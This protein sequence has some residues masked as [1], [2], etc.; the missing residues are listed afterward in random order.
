MLSLKKKRLVYF[1]G[2][3]KTE[4]NARMSGILGGKG[5]GLAEMSRMGI[6][7][8]AGFT[9]ST[10][11][12][13]FFY[14]NGK[15]YPNSLK[16]EVENNLKKLEI[17]TGKSFGRGENPLLVSVRSGAAVSMPGMM[18]TILNLGI[19]NEVVESLAK[20]TNDERFAYD[21]YRRFIQMFGN[22]VKK[23]QIEEFEDAILKVK[24]KYN[25]ED[26]KKLQKM[27]LKEIIDLYFQIY[28]K[29]V[30][31]AFPQDPLKQ[32][33]MAIDAV[34][35]SW[36]NERAIKFREFNKIKNISGTAV[37]IQSMVFG[38]YGENSGTGVCFSRNPSTG[39]KEIY[40]EYLQNAQG[41]DVVAGIR[42]PK[43]IDELKK[44]F[45]EIYIQLF[46]AIQKLENHYRD[47]Q[48]IEFTVSDGKLYLLQ[49]RSGKRT[50]VASVKCAV[51]MVREGL[52]SKEEAIKRVK[53]EDIQQTLFPRIL[54][55]E[56]KR[57]INEKLLIASGLNASIGA[58][59]GEIVFNSND[60][61]KA[62][63][64]GKKVVL[65]RQNTSPEDIAGMIVAEAV[66]TATG[67]MTSHAAIVSRSIG[68]PCV[69]CP[70]AIIFN[71]S[72]NSVAINGKI[73]HKGDFITID[74]TNGRVFSGKLELSKNDIGSDVKE[75]LSWCDDICSAS[76]RK[77][78]FGKN[79]VLLKGFY[80]MANADL[81]NDAMTALNFGA[82]GIG[83]CR[84]EHMF[85][86][87]EKLMP[88]RAMICSDTK[89]DRIAYLR[90]I[91][92]LQ[93]V[94]F[95]G[96]FFQMN[97]KEVIVRLLDPPLHEFLPKNEEELQKLS[98]YMNKDVDALRER[99]HSL[100]ETN[101]MMGHRGCRLAI[102]YPEIYEAQVEAVAKAL[103]SVSNQGIKVKA[104][105]M[106]PI[107]C[108]AEELREVRA[109]CERKIQVVIDSFS[110]KKEQE[111]A[112]L[113]LNK[114]EIGTMIET[115]RA[116][117]TADKIAEYADFF[118]FGTNDLTQTT[119]AFS[120][121]DVN[122]MLGLYLKKEILKNDPFKTIDKSGVGELLKMA[123]RRGKS[124]NKLM[125]MGI[126]G[127]H[128]GDEK[129]IK[130]CF[131]NGLSYVSCSP[132]RVPVARLSCAK[133]VLS[134]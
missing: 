88:F 81:P 91:C 42:T 83:L 86:D 118:S 109:I 30:G 3:N 54:E 16:G 50:G 39:E 120:R 111:E 2:G 115:P 6:P 121:D 15:K 24:S 65:V 97:G 18:D 67:G 80:V 23:I 128:G 29:R 95:E 98:K 46:D 59:C 75:L 26:D 66:L 43:K 35:S 117:L 99:V 8:P 96:I 12:C 122:E 104:K 41:E 84:T 108:D 5:A 63:K 90:Q 49:T 36:N 58:G 10:E 73:F 45:P 133:A 131:E 64:E 93:S 113:I 130:F 112:K 37:N 82:K 125:S 7:V 13:S 47:M 89:D 62:K 114:I 57:A 77:F 19:N 17:L 110:N 31:E 33:W 123:V 129:T 107:V 55:S 76:V 56:E 106:I 134:K 11:V 71:E 132:Y 32:L 40:G 1:F 38:N 69:I 21:T 94:D 87:K 34:F 124:I 70:N 101:P 127:E 79:K 14:K 51:D 126:C 119:F 60:A 92:E 48:D 25:I 52:I 78:K 9:I 103:L 22:V 74:G 102:T 61:E 4:G 85:F 28:Q 27:E 100:K 68:T 72:D 53:A 105:I 116:S 44:Q 20:K